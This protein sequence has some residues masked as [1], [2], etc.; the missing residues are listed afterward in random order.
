M[1]PNSRLLQIENM[2]GFIECKNEKKICPFFGLKVIILCTI[3]LFT[4]YNTEYS[5]AQL[6]TIVVATMTQQ[7]YGRKVQHKIFCR[8]HTYVQ[9]KYNFKNI[10]F[11]S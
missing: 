10:I 2:Q 11:V 3:I 6:G 7:K 9:C 5:Y 4:S 8:Y 1:G